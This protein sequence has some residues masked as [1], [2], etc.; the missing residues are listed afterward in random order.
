MNKHVESA[1]EHLDRATH[2]L[3]NAAQE[4]AVVQ[5]RQAISDSLRGIAS[6]A[7]RLR[8]VLADESMAAELS[9]AELGPEPDEFGQGVE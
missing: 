8:R 6:W 4:T 5:G 1:L 9:A 7:L 3:D 2:H